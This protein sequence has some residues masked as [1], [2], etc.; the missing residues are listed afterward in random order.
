MKIAIGHDL[1]E[2][3]TDGNPQSFSAMWKAQADQIGIEAEVIDPLLPGAIARIG[4]YDA[5]IWRY[6]FQFPWTD[7][8]RLRLLLSDLDD[9]EVV[10][11]RFA[12]L[13]ADPGAAETAGRRRVPGP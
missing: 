11:D 10:I 12:D 2:R 5:F 6:N 13:H 1:I 9:L 8:A 4:G 7:A 3:H